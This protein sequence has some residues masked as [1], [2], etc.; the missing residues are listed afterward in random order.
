MNSKRA[1]SAINQAGVCVSAPD[2]L[3]PGI[4]EPTVQY[5]SAEQNIVP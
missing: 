1:D 4:Y 3:G 5:I 2:R